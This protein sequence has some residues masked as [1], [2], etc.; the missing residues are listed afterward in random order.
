MW[1]A[2]LG[3]TMYSPTT[4]LPPPFFGTFYQIDSCSSTLSL[5]QQ[6]CS[7]LPTI[8][9]YI[10]RQL[11]RTPHTVNKSKIRVT[12]NTTATTILGNRTPKILRNI[13]S[14]GD[15]NPGQPITSRYSCLYPANKI[16]TLSLLSI[17]K[18]RSCSTKTRPE[19]SN[20]PYLT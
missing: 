7:T 12:T 2:K 9:F 20:R 10:S 11:L 5:C 3:F 14:H 4:L 18:K 13:A 19:N 6:R 8:T 15:Y 16:P 1:P 17:G